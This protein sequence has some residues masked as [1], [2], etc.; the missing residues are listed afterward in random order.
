MRYIV[1]IIVTALFASCTKVVDVDLNNA[2]PQ[3]VVEGSVDN[4]SPVATVALS[5]SVPFTTANVYPPV[6]G[7]AV[8]IKDITANINA[9]LTEAPAGVYTTSLVPGIPG[10]TYRLTINA[11]G[12]T[13]TAE[14]T[15]PPVTPVLDSVSF[16]HIITF[17]NDFINPVP[18]FLDPA[19]MSNYYSFI[20]AI[21][22]RPKKK[23]F[24]FDDRLS[25]GRYMTRQLVND[26]AYIKAGDTVELEMRCVD[27]AVFNYLKELSGVD[28]NNG[29][30]V[31]PGNP[32]SNISGG[33][34]GYFSAHSSQKKKAVAR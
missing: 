26:S 9:S 33:A 14:S 17:G 20:Q 21:S 15:M 28:Q 2:A 27:A 16:L 4:A 13:Y 32:T 34:L 6:S 1:L 29:Q 18:N 31:S 10:H 22:G 23:L 8:S 30:P 12:K 19:G 7:A 11:E 3:L 5:R 24:V 25:D